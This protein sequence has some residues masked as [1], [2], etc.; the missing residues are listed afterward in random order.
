ML[1]RSLELVSFIK[2]AKIDAVYTSGDLMAKLYDNLPCDLQ[3][4]K[5][6][7]IDELLPILRAQLRDGD[8]VLFK[9]S[10]GSNIYI[11]VEEFL[12]L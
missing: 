2:K 6:K 4:K 12:C 8:A 1:F 9:G 7:T 10:H 3:A 5:C 11:I